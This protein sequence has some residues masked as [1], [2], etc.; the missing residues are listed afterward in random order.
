[1]GDENVHDL[2]IELERLPDKQQWTNNYMT[3]VL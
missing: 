1:M 2:T 3:M